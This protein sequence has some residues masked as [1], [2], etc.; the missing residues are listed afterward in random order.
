MPLP[1]YAD[2]VVDWMTGT[3]QYACPGFAHA[4]AGHREPVNL[5]KGD[6]FSAGVLLYVLLTGTLP[7]PLPEEAPYAE[8]SAYF[9]RRVSNCLS[10]HNNPSL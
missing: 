7:T 1:L 2:G 5:R 8:Y 6:S 10:R 4:G 3:I 9:S